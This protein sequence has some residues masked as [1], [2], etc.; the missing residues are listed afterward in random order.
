MITLD[1]GKS[2]PGDVVHAR[3]QVA[4]DALATVRVHYPA[5]TH[6]RFLHNDVVVEVWPDDTEESVVAR[7]RDRLDTYVPRHRAAT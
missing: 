4:L 2:M 1:L 3:A 6:A 7:Y 5:L